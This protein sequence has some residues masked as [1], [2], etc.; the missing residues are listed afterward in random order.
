MAMPEEINR[1]VT[2]RLSDLLLTPDEI[3]SQNLISEGVPTDRIR[4]VGNIMIDTLEANIEKAAKLDIKE[5]LDENLI[6]E[7]GR[8]ASISK[9]EFDR[10]AVLTLHRPSNREHGGASVLVG[11]DVEKIKR[12]FKDSLHQTR[13]PRRPFLWDGRTAERIVQVLASS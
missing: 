4:F 10:L 1:L 13:I 6:S 3:S 9:S 12:S 2:D 8:M 7:N 5:I 11:N